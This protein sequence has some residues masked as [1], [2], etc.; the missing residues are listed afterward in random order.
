[1]E[2]VEKMLD[3][4]LMHASISRQVSLVSCREYAPVIQSGCATVIAVTHAAFLHYVLL[5]STVA[6]L[7][8]LYFTKDPTNVQ[9]YSKHGTQHSAGHI[10][11]MV[12]SHAFAEVFL[13]SCTVFC[14]L[15]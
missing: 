4:S 5:L 8:R 6:D 3:Q 9:I 14:M 13:Q 10:G 7:T 12:L 2:E 1:M 15:S 11:V